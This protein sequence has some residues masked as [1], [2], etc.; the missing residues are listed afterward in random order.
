MS[1]HTQTL[2]HA[3]SIETQRLDAFVDAAF[4]FAVSLLIIAGGE[5]LRSYND[6]LVALARIPAFAGGF[7]LIIM[8]W[9]AHRSWSSLSPVRNGGTTLL[10][11]TVVLAVLVF[12]FPLRLLIETATH[13]LS[14]GLLPGRG[15]I[16]SFA[17]LR[18][19]YVIYGIGFA[20]LS[21]LYVMLFRQARRTLDPSDTARRADAASW[22]RTWI[23]A[24]GA[25]LASSLVASTPVLASAPW[26]P[27]VTYQ[28][29]PLGIGLFALWDRRRLRGV[30]RD[31]TAPD[32]RLGRSPPTT[33]P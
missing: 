33:G 19:T 7:A 28:L 16:S 10:S 5:P 26:L 17:E 21:G 32:V 12:V 25:G 30:P 4:A 11:L 9:L 3:R 27:G 31:L 23:L 22:S 14:G 18:G 29:I 24:M 15:L 8:F 6:L 20:V 1:D 2:S 13:F